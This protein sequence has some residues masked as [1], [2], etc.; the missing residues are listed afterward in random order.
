MFYVTA[1]PR[2]TEGVPLESEFSELIGY[3]HEVRR[4]TP[5]QDLTNVATY[6]TVK[7]AQ[8]AAEAANRQANR[9]IARFNA[10]RRRHA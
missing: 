2:Y 1:H 6:P 4:A 8:E 5:W 9:E 10:A 3:D 7:A